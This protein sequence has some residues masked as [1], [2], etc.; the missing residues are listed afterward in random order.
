MSEDQDWDKIVMA[1]DGLSEGQDVWVNYGQHAGKKARV[2]D[3]L[4]GF[5]VVKLGDGSK[6]SLHESDVKTTQ[7]AASARSKRERE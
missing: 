2:V 6:I 7:P 4:N 3:V 1:L 5:V